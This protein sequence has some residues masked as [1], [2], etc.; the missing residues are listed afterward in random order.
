[1]K[2]KKKKV[3]RPTYP[4]FWGYVTQITHIFLFGQIKKERVETLDKKTK[5]KNVQ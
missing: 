1:M 2:K 4:I 3:K 5:N